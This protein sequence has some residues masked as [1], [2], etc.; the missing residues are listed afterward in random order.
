MVKKVEKL[1]HSD[2]EVMRYI[3][4]VTEQYKDGQKVIGEQYFDLKKD[5]GGLKRD[6]TVLKKD[7]TELKKDMT[8]VKNTQKSHTEMIGNLAVDAETLK[9]DMKVVKSD[10]QIIKTDVEPRVAHLEARS[11]SR[12]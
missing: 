4:V 11:A 1:T 10:L 7:V 9:D 12:N 8:E 2:S 3:G 6:I 5:I